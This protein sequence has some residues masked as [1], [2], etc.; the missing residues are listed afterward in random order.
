MVLSGQGIRSAKN[1]DHQT[2]VDLYEREDT[3]YKVDS[4]SQIQIIS[5]GAKD[6]DELQVPAE[7]KI[8]LKRR[9]NY[10]NRLLNDSIFSNKEKSY[11][12]DF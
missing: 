2:E 4:N 10:M 3:L 6:Y 12:K 5:R 9:E 7:F 8:G 1:L 11:R